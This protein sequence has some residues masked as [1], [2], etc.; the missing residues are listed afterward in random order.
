MNSAL[1]SAAAS[2][3]GGASTPAAARAR[4]P[5]FGRRA[6]RPSPAD[7]TTVSAR[8]NVG[9]RPARSAR[10]ASGLFAAGSA[11]SSS[12]RARL[13]SGVLVSK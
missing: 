1:S 6:V 7:V 10:W 5:D 9:R 8:A 11:A 4:R 13:G 3:A 2:S 12:A